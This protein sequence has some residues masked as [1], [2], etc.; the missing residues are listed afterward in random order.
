MKVRIAIGMTLMLAVV[1][2][3]FGF[4]IYLGMTGHEVAAVLLILSSLWQTPVA[5]IIA[6]LTMIGT[7]PLWA[8][9]K[10]RKVD[11]I[12]ISATML[13]HLALD[14]DANE[15]I[16]DSMRAELMREEPPLRWRLADLRWCWTN[17]TRAIGGLRPAPLPYEEMIEV[18]TNTSAR[19]VEMNSTTIVMTR[20]RIYPRMKQ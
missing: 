10:N 16:A 2:P 6:R 1:V 5:W 20:R 7:G 8:L 19:D 9:W 15:M 13:R 3:F 11:E 18:S 17:A 14:P 12:A 4:A